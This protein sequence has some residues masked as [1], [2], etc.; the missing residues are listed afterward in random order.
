MTEPK[1]AK[2]W[3][4]VYDGDVEVDSL[5]AQDKFEVKREL[6]KW[7]GK[8]TK[9]VVM[10]PKGRK[11]VAEYVPHPTRNQWMRADRFEDD[12]EE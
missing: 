5:Y 6:Q 10:R 1:T 4:T 11:P 9:A 2:L 8:A 3:V 7:L 12:R